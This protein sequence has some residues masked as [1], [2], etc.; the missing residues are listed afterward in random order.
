MMKTKTTLFIII[1]AFVI[2]SCATNKNISNEKLYNTI[3]ELGYISGPRIAFD[4]LYPDKKPKISFN[5]ENNEVSGNNS[6]NGYTANYTI[7]GNSIFFGEPEPTTMMFCGEGEKVFLN[8][9]KKINKYSFDQDGKL[10]LIIDDVPM[11]RFKKA[12]TKTIND[13][14]KSKPATVPENQI[15]NKADVYF[16][17]SGTEPF[18]F[19][20]LSEQQIK[21]KT[22]TD[23][24][25]TPY[26]APLQARDSNVKMY[27]IQTESSRLNMQITQSEC[28]DA[29]SGKLSP[30]T[31]SVEYK[32]NAE[33]SLHKIEGCGAYITDY[34]LHDIWVLEKLNGKSMDKTNF[35]S[36]LPSMEIN[37]TTKAF[38][39]FAGCNRMN[40]KLFFEKE[41]LRF[42]DIA[43]TKMMCDS[44]NNE[45]A[46]LKA[47][48]TATTYKIENNRLWLSNPSEEL[49]IFKKID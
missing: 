37:S 27:K 18:W 31:V 35:N 29:M 45:N 19:L 24:I 1:F 46:F 9:M 30:Y 44:D 36:D 47:F 21:L 20:E 43:T 26:T 49:L 23:S 33:P 4:G 41:L 7:T 32:K 34:R 15:N 14:A 5:K 25:I 6:C 39:G 40:G 10:N 12:G 42:T 16:K 48:R 11:M 17:A 13:L 22:I 28:T 8:M 3:W 2:I 38:T